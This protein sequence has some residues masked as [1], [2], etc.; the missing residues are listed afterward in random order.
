MAKIEATGATNAALDEARKLVT[1][2]IEA[3]S[4]LPEST[5]RDALEALAHHLVD[6]IS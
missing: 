3:L 2:G 6:R 5:Y 1:R 4:A